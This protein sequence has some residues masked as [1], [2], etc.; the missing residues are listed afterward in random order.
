MVWR[1]DQIEQRR[2][3]RTDV[4]HLPC[5]NAQRLLPTVETK[6]P[7]TPLITAASCVAFLYIRKR[8]LF[9]SQ[10]LSAQ[11]QSRETAGKLDAN[12]LL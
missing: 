1:R 12:K 9:S 3:T 10:A 4:P 2:N 6:W 8:R 11:N 5:A 7:Q